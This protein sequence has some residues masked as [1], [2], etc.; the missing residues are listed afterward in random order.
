VLRE[1]SKHSLVKW[2]KARSEEKKTWL[3]KIPAG[4]GK[5]EG[6]QENI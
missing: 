2:K 3:K 6:S 5:G 1:K 4:T